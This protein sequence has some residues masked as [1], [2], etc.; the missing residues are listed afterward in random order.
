MNSALNEKE[1][2]SSSDDEFNTVYPLKIRKLSSRHWTPVSVAKRAGE[3]LADREGVKVLDIGSGV[4]KFCLVA[5]IYSHGHFTGVEQRE[6]LIR[7]STKVATKFRVER[8]NFIQADIRSID[9]RDYDAFYFFNSFEENQDPTD[10][11]DEDTQYDPSLY[12]ANSRFLYQQ[13]DVLP[14]GTRIVTYCTLSD[15][16]PEGYVQIKSEIKGKLK[17]WIKRH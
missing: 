3:F 8:V 17:F 5:A 14:E 2:Y 6:A 1:I 9:F 11:I 15:I 4:G 10:K 16:I 7:I 13:F 12:E